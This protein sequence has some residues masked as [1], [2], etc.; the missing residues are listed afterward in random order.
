MD[1]ADTTLS[2]LR[3]ISIENAN[4]IS[5]SHWPSEITDEAAAHWAGVQVRQFVRRSEGAAFGTS[6]PIYR[7]SRTALERLVKDGK[8]VRWS[9]GLSALVSY[10]PIGL[11]AELRDKVS[12]A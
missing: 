8:A 2:L 6:T 4:Q 3:K 5:R 12:S 10:W 1:K 7:R 11:A 9:P